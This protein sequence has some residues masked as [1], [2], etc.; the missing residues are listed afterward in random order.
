MRNTAIGWLGVI[1]WIPLACA[2]DLAEQEEQEPPTVE[3]Q[4]QAEPAPPS[5]VAPNPAPEQPAAN[6]APNAPNAA[7]NAPAKPAPADSAWADLA[8]SV[9]LTYS[10]WGHVDDEAR[11]APYLCRLPRP[12]QARMSAS[13]HSGTHGR[14]LYLLS[15]MDP[16]AYGAPASA[17]ID[18]DVARIKGLEQAIVKEAFAP[19]PMDGPGGR[20]LHEPRPAVHEGKQFGLGDPKGLYVMMKVEGDRTGTDEGWVYATFAADGRELTSIGQLDS[21][22]ACHEKA[23]PGRLFGLPGADKLRHPPGP[24]P[25]G[26]K[27]LQ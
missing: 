12:A 2:G 8:V 7:P 17:M 13:E 14:K 6:P 18:G 5:E 26:N 20:T 27:K 10:G 4:A 15:A 23:G 24:G 22:M 3:A 21:C 11:W 16:V 19:K 25:D 9:A 1:A